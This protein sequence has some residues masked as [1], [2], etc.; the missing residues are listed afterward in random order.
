MTWG[1]RF[2]QQPVHSVRSLL[3][4]VPDLFENQLT[5]TLNGDVILVAIGLLGGNQPAHVHDAHLQ[6]PPV[7]KCGAAPRLVKRVNARRLTKDVQIECLAPV[8]DGEMDAM[9]APEIPQFE[10]RQEPQPGLQ[11]S[12]RPPQAHK[13]ARGWLNPQVS[14]QRELAHAVCYRRLATDDQVLHSG[15]LKRTQDALERQ[16]RG[17][18]C[19]VC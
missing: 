18:V 19:F 3:R 15:F 2:S 8:R 4:L 12:Q 5:E 13:I 17:F 16:S 7:N 11:A 10:G 1:A 14:V 9:P 6:T